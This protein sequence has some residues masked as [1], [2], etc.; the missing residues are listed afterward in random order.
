MRSVLCVLAMQRPVFLCQAGLWHF[1][2]SAA[3]L[4]ARTDVHLDELSSATIS[5]RRGDERKPN[6][7]GKL[8]CCREG[9]PREKKY[10]AQGTEV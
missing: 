4:Q 7:Q 9:V 8:H 1:N 3:S 5:L 6:E 10:G 2:L